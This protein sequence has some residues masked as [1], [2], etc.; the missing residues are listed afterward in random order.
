MNFFTSDWYKNKKVC[1]NS[2]IYYSYMSENYD[3]Y[4][5][6]YKDFNCIATGQFVFHDSMICNKFWKDNNLYLELL[7]IALDNKKSLHLIFEEAEIVEEPVMVEGMDIVSEELYCSSNESEMHFLLFDDENCI[8]TNFTVKCKNIQLVYIKEPKLDLLIS[9]FTDFFSY[10]KKRNRKLRKIEENNLKKK[11]EYSQ[12]KHDCNNT[13]I[14]LSYQ[15]FLANPSENIISIL[16]NNPID[17]QYN[18]YYIDCQS[19]SEKEKVLS[20]WIDAYENELYNAKNRLKV[21]V[22]E[23]NEDIK[24]SIETYINISLSYVDSFSV[25]SDKLNEIISEKNGNKSI[26]SLF[27]LLSFIRKNALHLIECV[28]MIDGNYHWIQNNIGD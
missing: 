25:L 11:I 14:F 9:L 19:L 6:W 5:Q 18:K 21:I 12:N 23:D 28:Y 8:T 13:K 24:K 27:N 4:P 1:E 2:Q 20:D 22:K 17:A 7:G 3:Y 26:N 15:S 10:F 16:D